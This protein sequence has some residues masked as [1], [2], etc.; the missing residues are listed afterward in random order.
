MIFGTKH[1]IKLK[2]NN[3]NI[4]CNDGTYLHRADQIK[5]VGV[6]LDPELSFKPHID[7]IL[8]KVNF[9]ISVL[10]RSKK[11]I[12]LMFKKNLLCNL[13]YLSLIMRM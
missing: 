1:M 7:C 6:W 9:G 13:Y 11:K 5:Y 8:R 3:L 10:Y 4:I 2:S 12:I